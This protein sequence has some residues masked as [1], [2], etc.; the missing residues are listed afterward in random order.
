MPD[1]RT[2][3]G[4]RASS[5]PRAVGATAGTPSGTGTVLPPA[6][7]GTPR[8]RQRIA[9]VVVLVLL[10]VLAGRLVHMQVVAGPALAAEHTAKRLH[11]QE[12]PGPRGEILDRNGVALAT[13]VERWNI[14][15]N[16]QQLVEALGTPEKVAQEAERLA[17]VL[18]VPAAELGAELWGGAEKRGFVYLAKGVVPEVYDQ[19]RDL[20]IPGISGEHATDRAYPA[21]NTAG[22]I[23]GF[24]GAEGFGQAG[25]EMIYEEVLEGTP[26]QLTY[27]RGARGQRIPGREQESVPAVPGRDVQLTIDRDVQYMAQR[28]LDQKVAESGA[29][30]GAVQVVDVRTGEI[31]ALVD[32]GAVDPNEPGATPARDRGSRAIEAVYEPG[33]TAKVISMAAALETG[34]AT[35]ESRFTVPYLYTTPNGQTFK[36]AHEHPTLQL[37]LAGVFAESSN[38]GTIMAGEAIPEQVRH[39]YLRK[40]GFGEPTGVGLPGESGGILWP[41]D[42]WDGRSG[43][44]VLFGQ[45]VS[46]TVMQNT[47]VFSTVANGGVRVQPHLVKGTTGPDGRLVPTELE[48]PER[49][50]AEETAQTLMRMLETTVVE[51]TGSNGA[52]P[53]YRVGGKTGTAQAFE[54]AGVIKH[55]ASFIGVAPVDDPRIAV[56]VVLYDPKTSIYGGAVAAPVFRD[57]TSFTLQHL[58]IPPT[59]TPP[60]LYP[61]TWE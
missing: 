41:A 60:E 42:T 23:L 49:V 32:S 47:Q 7:T 28:A 38:T 35:P 11:T 50:I 46:S 30:W 56:N 4:A 40:F 15:V 6:R 55:V 48:E 1:H 21:G 22:N 27:E 57:V 13:S 14:V 18:G 45:A 16:Q 51:G 3:V 2:T 26:G 61:T 58:G 8:E 12:I 52:I 54:G 43:Y 33:S 20:R 31:L 17:P 29:Q 53:G 25:I 19:V 34:T 24:V 10:A 9:L 59:G 44:A 39:D 5:P 36:D 37:T